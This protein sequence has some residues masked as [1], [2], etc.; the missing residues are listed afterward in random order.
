M[1]ILDLEVEQI[2]FIGAFLNNDL[3]IDI[4]IKLPKR[5]DLYNKY[6]KNL[7]DKFGYN[8]KVDQVIH[9]QKALYSFK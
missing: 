5:L 4:Y 2:D 8:P 6:S 7:L 9:I 3:D 1:A